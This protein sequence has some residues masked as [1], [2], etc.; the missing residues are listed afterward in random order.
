MRKA[1]RLRKISFAIGTIQI[2][3]FLGLIIAQI[4]HP[5][6]F[7]LER[8]T[9]VSKEDTEMS[10]FD[11]EYQYQAEVLLDF[12]R[13]KDITISTTSFCHNLSAGQ[14]YVFIYWG[15]KKDIHQPLPTLEDENKYYS[16]VSLVSFSSFS[17]ITWCYILFQLIQGFLLIGGIALLLL[18]KR[19]S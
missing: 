2:L 17:W 12:Y 11:P 15:L 18:P 4:A 8:G 9:V 1:N 14:S 19:L 5:Y 3:L 13:E 10:C 6:T 7:G 16:N